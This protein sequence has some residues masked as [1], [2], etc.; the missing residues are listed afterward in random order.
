MLLKPI[1]SDTT[2]IIEH[3]GYAFTLRQWVKFLDSQIPYDTLRM[4]YRRGLRGDE[5]FKQV[6]PKE[7]LDVNEP[8]A[9]AVEHE[10]ETHN[11]AEWSRRTGIGVGTLYSRYYA[12]KRGHDLFKPVRAYAKASKD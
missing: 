9:Y 5:L 6:Q 1:E 4:R 8:N 2:K 3:D 7:H 12:G 10:G 11:L